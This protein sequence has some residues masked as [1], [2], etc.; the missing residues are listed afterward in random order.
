M[1]KN[2]YEYKVMPF[3]VHHDHN[4]RLEDAGELQA[5]LNELG[6]D[7]WKFDK[8]VS[9]KSDTLAVYIRETS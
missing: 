3:G 1:A 2:K 5:A 6:K 7:G 9:L 4:G 8:T